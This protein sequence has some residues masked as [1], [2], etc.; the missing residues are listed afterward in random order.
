MVKYLYTSR[1][2]TARR[3]YEQFLKLFPSEIFVNGWSL[4]GGISIIKRLLRKSPR[5]FG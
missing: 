3:F 1:V 4:G 5:P 2:L